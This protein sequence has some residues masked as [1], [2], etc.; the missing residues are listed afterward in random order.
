MMRRSEE[1]RGVRSSNSVIHADEGG[2]TVGRNT[3]GARM[4]RGRDANS[5]AHAQ[6]DFK[7]LLRAAAEG[8]AKKVEAC[9]DGGVYVHSKD[10]DGDHPLHLAS[11]LHTSPPCEC[12]GEAGGSKGPGGGRS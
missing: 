5:V 1:I 3:G 12:D 8:D 2:R 7:Q 9:L 4:R 10:K 11:R 6:Y